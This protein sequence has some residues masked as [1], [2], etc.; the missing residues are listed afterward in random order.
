MLVPIVSP[1][2]AATVY[3]AFLGGRQ[4]E[5]GLPLL[6]HHSSVPRSY[7]AHSSSPLLFPP[8]PTLVPPFLKHAKRL[9]FL[10]SSSSSLT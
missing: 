4:A 9:R 7:V 1:A 6:P 5:R 2:A 8:L 3:P 10:P